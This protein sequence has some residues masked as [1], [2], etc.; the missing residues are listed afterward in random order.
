MGV[1]FHSVRRLW[2]DEELGSIYHIIMNVS[3]FARML[4]IA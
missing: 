3:S 2:D 1:P 4:K